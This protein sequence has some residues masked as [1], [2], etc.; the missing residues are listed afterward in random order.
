M[1]DIARER[2]RRK[3]RSRVW[4][5][6]VSVEREVATARKEQA[7]ADRRHNPQQVAITETI[8]NT[9]D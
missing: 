5:L 9:H 4:W 8:H 1:T 7:L 2:S 3:T 6:D